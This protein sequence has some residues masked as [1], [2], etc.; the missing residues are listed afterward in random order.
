MRSKLQLLLL[1]VVLFMD[2]TNAN[3]EECT[4]RAE[5]VHPQTCCSLPEFFTLEVRKAC[6][7]EMAAINLVEKNETY[8]SCYISCGLRNAGITDGEEIVLEKFNNYIDVVFKDHKELRLLASEAFSNCSKQVGEYNE[9]ISKDSNVPPAPPGCTYSHAFALS[10]AAKIVVDNC[11]ASLWNDKQEC[12]EA[13]D[14]F[15]QCRYHVWMTAD[16]KI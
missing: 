5:F 13:R 16:V 2:L 6:N 8:S 15:K 1:I 10:C 3:S 12:K 9:R 7:E 14:Y 4:K 11:P